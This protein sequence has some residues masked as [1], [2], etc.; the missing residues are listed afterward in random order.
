[1]G[2]REAP[3]EREEGQRHET[4]R[5]RGG[6]LAIP[7]HPVLIA[8]YPILFI[9]ARNLGEVDPAETFGP[10]AVSVGLTLIAVGVLRLLR[11]PWRKAAMLGSLAAI[12]V[13][14]YGQYVGV[15][16]PLGLSPGWTLVAWLGV[17]AIAAVAVVATRRSLV[18]VTTLLNVVAAVLVA[19]ELVTIGGGLAR[20]ASAAPVAPPSGAPTVAPSGSRPVA[21][22]G[23]RDIYYLVVEDYGSRRSLDQYLDIDDDGFFDWLAEAGFAVLPDTRSNYGRTPLSMASSLNMT[24]LDDVARAEGPD[25][26]RY[27]PINAMVSRSAVASF[28]KDRGYSV[29]QLGSQYYLTARSELADVNPVFDRTSDFLSVLY[30]STIIPPIANRVGLGD[31]FT[32]RRLNY[33]AAT[34]SLG[35]FPRLRDLPGPKFVFYHLFLPHH[36]FVVDREGR[37]VTARADASRTLQEQYQTQW[38]FVHREMRSIIEGLLSGP[39]ESRPIII[40]TT[41]E[42]PNP[43]NMPLIEGDIDW[44][45]ATDAQLDQKFS[46]FAAYYLPGVDDSTLYPGMSSVNSFRFVFDRYFDAD[47]PLLPDRSYIHQDK[48]HPYVLTDVTDRLPEPTG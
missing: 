39:E 18:G 28:L 5:S 30:E 24:Y 6:R 32:E 15:S 8:S 47:L 13:L 27:A 41:D 48:H 38:S 19:S 26:D 34:W 11:L 37:Y 23:S 43:P 3:V 2:R 40:L 22:P 17:A 9:L 1:M 14:L 25:S 35:E 45:R 42:G 21:A 16:R 44:S 4:G 7:F 31:A 29:A 46:I 10:I 12:V 33:E 36:P 20:S